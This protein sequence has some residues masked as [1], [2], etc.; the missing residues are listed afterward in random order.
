MPDSDR[1][2]YVR[3][4]NLARLRDQDDW[5]NWKIKAPAYFMKRRLTA[6]IKSERPVMILRLL[7]EPELQRNAAAR[8]LL[9]QAA[10]ENQEIL[11]EIPEA[12]T[13]VMENEDE[14][15]R[16]TQ[17]WFEANI[18]LWA[19]LIGACEG[20][21]LLIVREV[22]EGDGRTAWKKLHTR[23]GGTTTTALTVKITDFFNTKYAPGQP[24]GEYVSLWKSMLHKLAESKL[25]FQGEFLACAFLRSLGTS[26]TTFCNYH[27]EAGTADPEV[28]YVKVVECTES[29]DEAMT[30]GSALFGGDTSMGKVPK[31]RYGP[32]CTALG[33]G[34]CTFYH[35][36]GDLKKAGGS[37]GG[38]GG[39]RGRGGN[40]GKGR[41]GHTEGQR[42]PEPDDWQCPGCDFSVWARKTTCPRCKRERG[43]DASTGARKRKREEL[44]DYKAQLAISEAN[45]ATSHAK[46]ATA[47][48]RIEASGVLIAHGLVAIE[49][50]EISA[51]VDVPERAHMSK[52]KGVIFKADTG[53]T[54]HFVGSDVTL[55]SWQ[56]DDTRVEIADGSQIRIAKKGKFTAETADGTGT[57]M[58]VK[59]A[60]E[61]SQ[62]LFSIFE[63]TKQGWQ[64]NFN[65]TNSFL[66]NGATGEQIPLTRT[67]T[68][69]DL[70]LFPTA[71]GT[72]TAAL[73]SSNNDPIEI[74]MPCDTE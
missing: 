57:I 61:F 18:D 73:A 24:I 45:L 46:I 41:G 14:Y 52:I 68:G 26:F 30:G 60:P 55:Q 62:N 44:K 56:S 59:Q 67:A 33:K 49:V 16:R 53:A 25:T 21:A 48:Q 19:E 3:G 20:E 13:M 2:D 6:P 11:A 28:L 29:T 15:N 47:I 66:M 74:C 9:V 43:G 27:R 12:A 58:S 63:A 17:Q 36:F 34:Q 54:S 7:T 51:S 32:R 71:N 1:S 5:E 22:E 69:W 37:R 31:C 70:E 64:A 10:G 40:R 42:Q 72:G 35:P 39:G 50:P 38:G 65:A 23:Y 4:R 8:E